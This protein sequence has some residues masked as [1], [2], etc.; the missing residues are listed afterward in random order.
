MDESP[1]TFNFA[2]P[3]N[4]P[5]QVKPRA[6]SGSLFNF[7]PSTSSS[8]RPVRTPQQ[9]SALASGDSFD[10]ASS[11]TP[12]SGGLSAMPQQQVKN[13]SGTL[14]DFNSSTSQPFGIS[15]PGTA[16][17]AMELQKEMKQVDSTGLQ[18][19]EFW[20]QP[21]RDSRLLGENDFARFPPE[22]QWK[23]ANA[24]D[25]LAFEMGL[26]DLDKSHKIL[27]AEKA[28]KM[29]EETN[30]SSKRKRGR[31]KKSQSLE[32]GQMKEGTGVLA[33]AKKMRKRELRSTK[34]K[35]LAKGLGEET[36]KK[37]N[38]SRPTLK[39]VNLEKVERRLRKQQLREAKEGALKIVT[40]EPGTAP[41]VPLDPVLLLV[42]F[43]HKESEHQRYTS[44]EI[45]VKSK[46]L[47]NLVHV[48]YEKFEQTLKVLT[49]TH[50]EDYDTY[51][52]LSRIDPAFLT[53]EERTL[54][55]DGR[56][57]QERIRW[58]LSRISNS[59]SAEDRLHE[60]PGNVLDLAIQALKP[61]LTMAAVSNFS[62][63]HKDTFTTMA[64]N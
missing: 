52:N 8:T 41:I 17:G 62:V 55:E 42:V 19:T 13:S 23:N 15:A 30:G 53:M 64:F 59:D 18:G 5:E 11:A 63:L 39:Q 3:P 43:L 58:E 1:P 36:T 45:G 49:P 57:N 47:Q 20:K 24:S 48:A 7:A 16:K 2:A 32:E 34:T 61:L 9:W 10:F 33:E 12:T 35:H 56:E 21:K 28:N 25:K 46:S 50:R 22:S 27:K 44:K 54:V 6:S 31:K 4:T 38:I 40:L 60:T 29:T 14:F 37:K 26:L 51:L